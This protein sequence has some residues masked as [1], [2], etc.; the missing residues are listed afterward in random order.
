[1]LEGE[2]LAIWLDLSKEQQGDYAA[3]KKEICTAMMPTEFVSLDG[4]H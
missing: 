1:M 4:F 3:V 2:A